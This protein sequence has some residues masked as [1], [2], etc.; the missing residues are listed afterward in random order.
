MGIFRVPLA[1]HL[2]LGQHAE[3]SVATEAGGLRTTRTV[4][5]RQLARGLHELP[6]ADDRFDLGGAWGFLPGRVPD[7]RADAW[8]DATT[9]AVPG[10]VAFDGLLPERGVATLRR[11]IG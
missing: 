2:P 6:P 8:R 1:R 7:P 3:L 5:T 9:T 11:V 10:H 4:D